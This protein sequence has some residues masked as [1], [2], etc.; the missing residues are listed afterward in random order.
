MIDWSKIK[1]T[2]E[3]HELY[4]KIARKVGLALGAPINHLTTIMD[5]ELCHKVACPLR[6]SELWSCANDGDLLHDVSGIHQ[7]LDRD[8]GELTNNFVPRYSQPEI[9]APIDIHPVTFKVHHDKEWDEWQVRVYVNGVL[10]EARTYH[11]DDKEDA[12]VTMA[13][14]ILE[15]ARNNA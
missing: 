11:T 13:T 10:N 3:E 12:E 4:G 8:T 5:L 14:M 15:E 2:K 1:S 9:P 7:Y 6:L